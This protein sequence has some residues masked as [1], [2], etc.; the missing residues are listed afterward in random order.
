[1]T[2]K[3]LGVLLIVVGCGGFGFSIAA[4]YRREEKTLRIL[5]TALDHM[6]C[7]LQ[8]RMPPLPDLC[9]RTA[10]QCT[11]GLRDVFIALA[12]ELEQQ[13]APDAT[14]CMTAALDRVPELTKRARSSM[15]ALGRTLGRFDVAGQI[16]GIESVRLA[17][18]R[19]LEELAHNRENRLR[20]YQT[21][22]LCAGAAL[23]ILFV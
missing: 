21:L 11:G 12:V 10:N 18:Q 17:C 13:L 15:K 3:L 14:R 19:D 20:S 5:L 2:I 6:E 22:G 7:E 23:A 4:N 9:R 8:Y 1:M 16:R